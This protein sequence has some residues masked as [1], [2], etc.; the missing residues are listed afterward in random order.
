MEIN[1]RWIKIFKDMW[2]HRERSILV[3]LSIAVGVAAYGMI[4]NTGRM[5]KRDLFS[6][7]QDAIPAHA[8][9]YISSFDAQLAAAVDDM[10]EVETVQMRRAVSAEV[11]DMAGERFAA[12]LLA[13]PDYSNIRV[14]RFTVEEGASAPGPRE[15][16][17]ERQTATG[18]GVGLGDSITV[19]TSDDRQYDLRVTGIVHDL[20]LF[21]F[22][23]SN[24]ATTYVSMETL[25]WMGQGDYYNRL[26]LLITPPGGED[27]TIDYV[28]DVVVDARERVIE[29]SG[30]VVGAIFTATG[31]GSQ[32]G[33]FWAQ[34][35]IDG[36]LLVLGIMSVLAIALSAGLVINTITAIITQ[37]IK[38]IG[39]MRSVGAVRKQ[40][41]S[42]YV[43]NVLTYSILGLLAGIPLG[44]LGAW[45]LNIFAGTFM[46]YD[47]GPV[48]ISLG[49]F[50]TQSILGVLMPVI[51]AFYPIV[52]GTQLTVYDAIY[53]YGLSSEGKRGLIDRI[54]VRIR[55]LS[56]PIMLSLRNTFRKKARLAFTLV[57][58][59][60]AG[61]MFMAVFST[62]ATLNQQIAEVVRYVDY[63]AALGVSSNVGRLAAEREAMRIPGVT[64]AE[65]VARVGG[66]VIEMDGSEG[67]NVG[68]FGVEPGIQTLDARLLEG[69]WLQDGDVDAVVI[70]DDIRASYPD[71]AVGDTLTV[72][73]NGVDRDF[74]IVGIASKH[75]FGGRVYMAYSAFSK[76]TGQ[77]NP[78]TEIRVRIDPDQVG[79]PSEQEAMATA[80]EDRF[81][82]AGLSSATASTQADAV[83]TFTEAFDIIL[84]VLLIMAVVLA[85][86]GGLSLTGT[87]GINVLERTREI[88]VLRAVGASNESVRQVVVVEGVVI[89]VLSWLISALLSAPLGRILAG[90]IIN[91][92]LQT[93]TTFRYSYPGLLIWL[94]IIVIIGIGSSLAPAFSAERLTVR[95]VL[96]YE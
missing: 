16:L 44:L 52:A 88:G 18:L 13:V 26:D 67:D 95:E 54:L 72:K 66:V 10:R 90:V 45:R 64:V 46:N 25:R 92:V 51:A 60:M 84:I 32:P 74:E 37:Q 35:P 42:M 70:N 2:D 14:A 12:S 87:M 1:T 19:E 57:T 83:A 7:Y 4:N 30:Y 5:V 48:N 20:T 68:V 85:I 77:T 11:F 22:A 75:L 78:I 40:I 41:I 47:P 36:F 79:T 21:P 6:Q 56:P 23:M 3:I 15:V 27:L 8:E 61:A 17:L 50:I 76:V 55:K 63:D 38:Q 80:L 39:I 73:V 33:E 53:Q 62:R 49:L 43:T 59:T 29:P 71:L 28:N 86:V 24:E 82:D 93:N 91:V 81:N 69:R 89:A 31:F 94:A 9:V 58:L 34:K 96:D 65:G